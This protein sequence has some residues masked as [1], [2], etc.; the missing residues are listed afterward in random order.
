MAS[1]STHRASSSATISC[2]CDVFLSFMGGDTRKNFTDHLYTTLV[3]YGIQT[4]R[5]DEKLEKGGDI[6]SD[7]STAIEESKIFLIIFSKN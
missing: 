6:T 2:N 4:F 7:L 1:S 5:D 3:A